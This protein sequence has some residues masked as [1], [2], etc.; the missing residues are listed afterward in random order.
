MYNVIAI[1]VLDALLVL[2]LHAGAVAWAAVA[3]SQQKSSAAT[4]ISVPAYPY[5]PVRLIVGFAPGG[6][7]VPAR[8][9]AQKLAEKLGQ[10]FVVDNRPGAS[11]VLGTAIA[12]KAPADGYT[13]V[14][15]TASHAVTAV[16]YRT[17]PFDPIKDFDPITFVGSIPFALAVTPSLP[18][19]SV[20]EFIA[21]ARAKPGG[22]NYA[23]PGTGSIGHLANVVFAK[24]AGIQATHVAYKG[25]GP[26]VA[27]LMSGEVQFMMPNLIGVA[28]LARSGKLKAL[29]V[30]GA[31]RSQIAPDLPTMAEAGVP[32]FVAATWYGVQAP[33]GTSQ[34]VVGLLNREI[35]AAIATPEL[36]EKLVALGIE[37]ETGT[38][39]A[40]AKFIRSEIE[41]WGAAMKDAGLAQ[42]SY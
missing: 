35:A 42:E 21:L 39:Q 40:F 34:P 9:I 8:L 7:D 25:T 5:R 33:R 32:D 2:S 23:S 19:N 26:S 10:P 6:S 28:A 13:L 38:P 11:G 37:L 16:Y 15:S 29:A 22:L 24:R 18:A 1:S 3:P 27:A 20:K 12:A 4:Q 36:R 30:A 17:L 31:R 41:R 14:F